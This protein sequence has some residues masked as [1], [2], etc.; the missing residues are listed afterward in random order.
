MILLLWMT[1]G[2]VAEVPLETYFSGYAQLEVEFGEYDS[3]WPVD[4]K[5]RLV[6][7]LLENDRDLSDRAKAETLIQGG[8]KGP[9]EDRVSILFFS[10]H[11]LAALPFS[12]STLVDNSCNHTAAY[13]I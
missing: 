11:A 1:S 12:K 7:L 4:A 8:L 3:S 5:I 9:E 2:A 13:A 10:S 6:A